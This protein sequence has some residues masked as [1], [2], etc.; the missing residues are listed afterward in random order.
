MSEH[1]Q[2]GDELD[3]NIL[4]NHNWDVLRRTMWNYVGIVR[5]SRR[6][7][8]ARQR[9]IAITRE[10]ESLYGSHRLTRNMVELRNIAHVSLMIIESA[11]QRRE[12]RGLHYS[13]DYPGRDESQRTWTVLSRAGDAEPWEFTSERVPFSLGP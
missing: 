13:T 9:I 3:E 8:L 5:N 12:S 7:E 11:R 1:D 6:L 4:I 10:I 2:G